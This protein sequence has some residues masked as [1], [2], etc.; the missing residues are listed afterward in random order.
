MAAWRRFEARRGFAEED[1]EG[2]W[3]L[4]AA[5]KGGR[6]V[7]YERLLALNFWDIVGVCGVVD[8]DVVRWDVGCG[9]WWEVAGLW[10]TG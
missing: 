2:F 5:R 9:R 10:W 7:S 8:V 4:K 3:D 6:V 1:E